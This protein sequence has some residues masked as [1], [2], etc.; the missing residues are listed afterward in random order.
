[1]KHTA[2]IAR[3]EYIKYVTRRGFLISVLMFPLWIGLAAVVP[4]FVARTIPTRVVTIV[5]HDGGYTA[6]ITDTFHRA[7]KQRELSALA[8]YAKSEANMAAFAKAEPAKAVILQH[9]ERQSALDAYSAQGGWQPIFAALSRFLKPDAK[10]FTPPRRGIRLVP[11]PAE[12]QQSTDMAKTAALYFEGKRGIAGGGRL[13]GILVIP[14]GFGGDTAGPAEFWTSSISD[15]VAESFLRS[16]LTEELRLRRAEAIVPGQ[17]ALAAAL[18]TI[19]PIEEH[20]PT[21]KGGSNPIVRTIATIVPMGFALLLFLATFTNANTLLLGVIDEKSTRMIEVLLSCA[22]PG[23]IM[24]GK[25]LGAVGAVLT[26][27]ALWGVGLFGMAMALSPQAAGAAIH[28]IGEIVTLTNAPLIALYFL[29]GL[30]IYGAIFLAIGSMAKSVADAQALL[31]PVTLIIIVP[32]MLVGAIVAA[33]NGIVARVLSWIPIYT[34]FFM[35]M[36]L[37]SHPPRFELWGTAIL[38]VATTA[39]LIA[40]MSNVFAHNVLATERPPAFG[41]VVRRLVS[42]ISRK[43]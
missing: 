25:L 1:M 12:V 35:L 27:L 34:P 36:R 5:D 8:R 9:P 22:S 18:R 28:A 15:T 38:T 13:N 17:P 4:N 42:R 6:A 19:A 21:Q 7:N 2:L 41:S 26:T 20:D 10:D 43:A 40:Q 11:A 14:K 37:A 32:N 23:E 3:H 33:P 16:A 29:C 24:S 31:G 39:Y 30:L